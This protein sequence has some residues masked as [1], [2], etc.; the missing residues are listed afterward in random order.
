MKTETTVMQICVKCV[1]DGQCVNGKQA[2]H[3]GVHIPPKAQTESEKPSNHHVHRA[4]VQS[5]CD[6]LT[7]TSDLLEISEESST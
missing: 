2:V 7:S 6:L 5:V 1:H 3:H 4:P